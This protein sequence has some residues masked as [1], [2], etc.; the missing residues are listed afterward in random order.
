MKGMQIILMSKAM[1]SIGLIL[2]KAKQKKLATHIN[3]IIAP[4]TLA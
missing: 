4:F 2:A 1:D 3:P